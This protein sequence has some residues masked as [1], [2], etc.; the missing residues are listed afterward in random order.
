MNNDYKSS[1]GDVDVYFRD[2][3]DVDFLKTHFH[4]V[5][6][7]IFVAEGTVKMGIADKS[8][9]VSRDSIVFISNLENH[10]AAILSPPYKR[11][12]ITLPQDFG[13]TVFNSSA[14]LSI[15]TQR[16][17]GFSHAIALNEKTAYIIREVLREMLNE[18]EKKEAFW[19][20]RLLS[21]AAKLLITLYRYSSAAFPVNEASEAAKIVSS[22]QRYIILNSQKDITLESMANRHFINKYYLSRIFR[23]IT[24]YKFKDYVIQQRLSAAKELLL[25]TDMSVTEVCLHSGYNNVNHFI[26]IFKSYE[27]TSPYQY[28][29]QHRD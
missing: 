5:H 29:K 1:R 4:N 21:L 19:A 27:G 2:R 23:S 13:H 16:P 14:L 17:P 15:L 20:E 18:N 9:T 12:V 26:R 25:H 6:K 7:I 10:S 8:Y 24:G 28:R 22:V 11:Y 3:P